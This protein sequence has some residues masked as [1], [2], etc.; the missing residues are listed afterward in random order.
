MCWAS[1][2]P[3]GGGSSFSREHEAYNWTSLMFLQVYRHDLSSEDCGDGSHCSAAPQGNHSGL[4][5]GP[6]C[7]S[8]TV[9]LTTDNK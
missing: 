5:E 7:F 3:R 4:P 9:T 1:H 2:W 6:G 8:Q